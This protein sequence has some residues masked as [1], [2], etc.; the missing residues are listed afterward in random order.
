M[1]SWID[2]LRSRCGPLTDAAAL[3]SA[4]S[5]LDRDPPAGAAGL[6]F[7]ARS[8][9]QLQG[10]P[11]QGE[12]HERVF[13][14]GAGSYLG[15]LLCNALPQARHVE[16]AGRHELAFGPRA[17]FDPF[18]AIERL[19]DADDVR[20]ALAREVALAEG[21]ARRAQGALSELRA[22]VQPRLVG[23][24][25]LAEV[26]RRVGGHALHAQ[27]FLPGVQLMFVRREGPRG[28]YMTEHEIA[29]LE[30]TPRQLLRLAL[31]NLARESGTARLFRLEHEAGPVV[32]ARTGD[33]L[34]ASRV[35]LPGL[36]DVLAP[37]LGSP[38]AVAIPHRDALLACSL[39]K[40]SCVELLR[41]RA[42]YEAAR[43]AYAITPE[44][45]QCGPEG[46]IELFHG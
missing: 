17:F 12:D 8:V 33:G 16:R 30:L 3:F 43:A 10:G 41:E 4:S 45:L 25:L 6:L 27:P 11:D 13:V 23:P 42:G 38:F 20:D 39:A 9:E 28:L 32:A 29:R 2:D 34:D 15:L 24:N 37:E 36:H 19:L 26:R 22:Q 14:E 44:L 18:A 46:R 21:A 7:L 1:A 5:S 31:E 35:L 40:P